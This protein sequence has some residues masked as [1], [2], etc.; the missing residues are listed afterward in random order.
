MRLAALDSPAARAL[1]ATTLVD[2]LGGGLLI[3]GSVIF[4]VQEIGLSEGEVGLGVA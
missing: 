3:A 4:Y 2:A 1:V